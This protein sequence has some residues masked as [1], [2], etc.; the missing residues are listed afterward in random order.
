MEKWNRSFSPYPRRKP[1]IKYISYQ[2]SN[3]LIQIQL[4]SIQ[5]LVPAKMSQPPNTVLDRECS[6]IDSDSATEESSENNNR[7]IQE[8]HPPPQPLQRT[9]ISHHIRTTRQEMSARRAIEANSCVIGLLLD[10]RRFST[11]AV[12]DLVDREWE[13]TGDVT[14][15]G[16]DEDRF[17]IYLSNEEDRRL[18]LERSPWNIEGA[19]FATTSW[20][21]STTIRETRIET[22]QIRMQIW[23][24]PFEYQ[25]ADMAQRLAQSAGE[26]VKIDWEYV[27]PRNIRFMR[28][29]DPRNAQFS[30]HMKAF[31]HRAGRRNNRLN[32]GN[33]H[34]RR[35]E[36]LWEHNLL[37]EG[38]YSPSQGSPNP[39]RAGPSGAS[40][41]RSPQ[42]RSLVSTEAQNAQEEDGNELTNHNGLEEEHTEVAQQSQEQVH[43][44]MESLMLRDRQNSQNRLQA[45]DRLT[46][47]EE[48]NL[49][50]PTEIEPT[51]AYTVIHST[52][53]HLAN[54]FEALP[55]LEVEI[56][57]LTEAQFVAPIQTLPLNLEAEPFVYQ[58]PTFGPLTDPRAEFEISADRLKQLEQRRERGQF[59]NLSDLEDLQ[60]S[61][62]RE[63]ARF[64]EQEMNAEKLASI[65]LDSGEEVNP[66]SPSF[67]CSINE[68]DMVTAFLR[69][70][71]S[72]EPETSPIVEDRDTGKQASESAKQAEDGDSSSQGKTQ[73]RKRLEDEIVVDEKDDQLMN[74]EDGRRIRRRSTPEDTEDLMEY[75]PEFTNVEGSRQAAPKQ[76]PTNQ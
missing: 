70:T 30:N 75:S 3:P 32:P 35:A 47:T 23:G 72:P 13:A 24:L 8:L 18:A 4:L 66:R 74:C 45:D 49:S 44:Q 56:P 65:S 22:I 38:P 52:D 19:L 41:E 39:F 58:Q 12:Q 26:V 55:S 5:S 62:N 14:V 15:I 2:H 42:W 25:Y 64:E 54:T 43:A 67:I 33:R 69:D 27:R 57:S 21:P 20:V 28:V 50:E 31:L 36:Q 10:F 16:R 59:Q 9:R 51:E 68:E 76:P 61:L 60:Y 63:Q 6:W 34:M 46:G 71:P 40:L 1:Y 11:Q 37:Q 17:L 7:D 48:L 29:R 73:K 53:K